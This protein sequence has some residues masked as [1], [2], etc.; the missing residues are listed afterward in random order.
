MTV[1]AELAWVVHDHQYYPGTGASLVPEYTA[2][3][4]VLTT[5]G[6]GLAIKAKAADEVS[7][8]FTLFPPN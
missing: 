4:L 6:I 5:I 1:Q 8:H 2:I 7:T 3:G